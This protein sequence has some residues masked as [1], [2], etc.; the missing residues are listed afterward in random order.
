MRWHGLPALI[1]VM[2]AVA[3]LRGVPD[4]P[5]KKKPLRDEERVQGTWISH[6]Q[7]RD[8][9]KFKASVRLVIQGSRWVLT[10]DN[11]ISKGTFKL[12]LAAKLKSFD[13]SVTEGFGMGI[14]AVGIYRLEGD[15]WTICWT[16]PERNRPTEFKTRPDDN[17]YLFIFQKTR[18]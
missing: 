15:R 7:E 2:L 14:K 13:A 8:G 11:D 10:I 3:N 18:R 12:N 9:K 16:V 6:V 17:C 5:S 4:R 1:V